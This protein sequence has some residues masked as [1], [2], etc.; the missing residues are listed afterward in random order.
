MSEKTNEELK[1]I[2]LSIIPLIN[3][4]SYTQIGEVFEKINFSVRNSPAEIVF[5]EYSNPYIK[6]AKTLSE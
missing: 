2:A 5:V 3:G 6:Y 4:L 1:E